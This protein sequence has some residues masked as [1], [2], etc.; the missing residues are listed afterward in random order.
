MALGA[1]STGVAGMVI[2]QGM[3]PVASGLLAG[4]VITL[5]FGTAIGGMLYQVHPA[6]PITFAGVTL[7]LG[8]VALLACWIPARRAADIAP[9][10]ALRYE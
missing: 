5:G 9:I 2:R 7:L 4:I 1:S 6:D 3:L 10:E 8:S